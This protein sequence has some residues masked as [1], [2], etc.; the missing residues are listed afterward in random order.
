MQV[1]WT[2]WDVTEDFVQHVLL[3]SL[4]FPPYV[5]MDMYSLVFPANPYMN[6]LPAIFVTKSTSALVGHNCKLLVR[7]EGYAYG[8]QGDDRS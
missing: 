2:A 5:L 7:D 3:A 1:S 4:Y 8:A 6:V